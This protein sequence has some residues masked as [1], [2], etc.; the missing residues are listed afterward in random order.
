MATGCLEM[1]LQRD[2]D[3][4]ARSYW[5]RGDCT[6]GVWQKEPPASR[7]FLCELRIIRSGKDLQAQAGE[8]VGRHEEEVFVELCP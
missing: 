4:D 2:G 5:P 7:G 1:P 3:V 8:I 6:G